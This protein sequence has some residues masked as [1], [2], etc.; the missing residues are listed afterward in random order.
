MLVIDMFMSAIATCVSA[1]KDVCDSFVILLQPDKI[2]AEE[3]KTVWLAFTHLIGYLG[4]LFVNLSL[5]DL[6]N[7]GHSTLV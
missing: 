4:Q 1:Y 2:S 7:R 3:N 6:L 5:N